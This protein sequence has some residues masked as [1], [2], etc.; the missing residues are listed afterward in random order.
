MKG[1]YIVHR[2]IRCLGVLM[3]SA[4][5]TRGERGTSVPRVTSAT[6]DAV[7]S[8]LG[9]GGGDCLHSALAGYPGWTVACGDA[10]VWP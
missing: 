5:G 10:Q 1:Q 3:L 4:A 8:E 9:E 7:L 2:V 6:N